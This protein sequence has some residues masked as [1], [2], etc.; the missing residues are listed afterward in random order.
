MPREQAAI[1]QIDV[2]VDPR[3]DSPRR[4]TLRSGVDGHPARGVVEDQRGDG[5]TLYL[6]LFH[7]EPIPLINAKGRQGVAVYW[8]AA[9]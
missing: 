4:S 9:P 5:L 2:P 8:N 6:V 1:D 7:T 3:A